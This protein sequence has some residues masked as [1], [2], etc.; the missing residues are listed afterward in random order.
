MILAENELLEPHR[1]KRTGIQLV[2]LILKV[3]EFEYTWLRK[4]LILIQRL[5]DS[6][7]REYIMHNEIT[8]V[9]E[10]QRG[11]KLHGFT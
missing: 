9:L 6:I 10:R 8:D 1:G 5:K 3:R 11:H 7:L 4:F 2:F